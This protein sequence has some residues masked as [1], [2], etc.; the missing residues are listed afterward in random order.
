ME[1]KKPKVIVIVG[2]TSSGKTSLSIE[3]AKAFN[4]EI[5]SADSRQVYRGLDLGSGKVTEVE[6][7][8]V[9]HHLLD[10]VDPQEVYTAAEFE[11]DA[12]EAIALIIGRGHVP[13]IA[14]GTFFYI[15][16]LLGKSSVPKVAPNPD[17][18][19][20]LETRS[21]EDLYAELLV[22]DPTRA[23]T[24]DSK[25]KRRLVRALEIVAALGA[26]PKE[27]LEKRYD[28]L[29]LGIAIPKET[30]HENIHVRLHER[31]EAGMIAEAERLRDEGVSYERLESFGLEYRYIAQFLQNKLSKDEMTARLEREIQH[32]AKRQ[33][34][35]LKRDKSIVWVDPK[36]ITNIAL[37]I[38]DFLS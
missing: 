6:K 16:V 17:L 3:L 31:L 19:L 22:K 38:T 11:K 7:D 30:L 2:P 27:T 12:T 9:S 33:M 15:D 20:Q 29:T 24:I 10:I 4:G 13:I 36:D 34:T 32:F 23:E 8:G 25:N 28:V 14:G 1:E 37:K 26:V 5:I 35:W 18:R 21:E